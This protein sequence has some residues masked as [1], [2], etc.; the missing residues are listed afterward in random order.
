MLAYLRVWFVSLLVLAFPSISYSQQ[1]VRI[2][3]LSYN[4]HHGE[5]VDGKLDLPR[6]GKVIISANPDIVALQEVDQNVSRS[7][8][9]DQA[10]ELARL[11]G[12]TSIFGANIEL[13]DGHYGN[14]LLSRF[15]VIGH[16]NH[17][18]PNV[19][20]GE[21]RGLLDAKLTVPG[22]DEPVRVMATHFDHR[23]D[24]Q[25]RVLSAQMVNGLIKNEPSPRLLL[26]DLNDT[27]DSQPLQVLLE[28]W[29]IT[30][31]TPLPT[32]PVK[33][34]KRQI[35]FVMF[36]PTSRWMTIETRVLDEAVASDHRPILSVL[37]LR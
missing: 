25:E 17:P 9:A 2:T 35:D 14:A 36:A 5:G 21:Q 8:G 33:E 31:P 15:A 26:G 22:V 3:V 24:D 4:I 27:V 12:L 6:I 28:S 10:A 34:P 11:T 13:Q 16:T 30:N 1:P 37:E 20:A 29:Q 32:I 18:L 23:R 19:N 7:G